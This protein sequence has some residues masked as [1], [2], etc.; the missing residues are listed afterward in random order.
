MFLD[1]LV[2][3]HFR[4]PRNR[5]LIVHNPRCLSLMTSNSGCF[6]IKNRNENAFF[7]EVDRVNC[8]KFETDCIFIEKLFIIKLWQ[9]LI[10]KNL[11]FVL[12]N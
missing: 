5:F 8:R 3:Y 10:N 2:V 11:R 4:G 12:V 6:R 9:N 7:A 1:G